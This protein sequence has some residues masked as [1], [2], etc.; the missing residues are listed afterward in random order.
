MMP[1]EEL[2]PLKGMVRSAKYVGI[3]E[4]IHTAG[5]YSDGRFR[6]T[7]FLIEEMGFRSVGIEAPY[8]AV[9]PINDYVSTC[10]GS[11]TEAGKSIYRPWKDQGFIDFIKWA[12]QYNKGH[13]KDPIYFYGFDAQYQTGYALDALKRYFIKANFPLSEKV[14]SK[15]EKCFGAESK[16]VDEFKKSESFKKYLAG[17]AIPESSHN[18]CL[19]GLEKTSVILQRHQKELI[20]K[21]SK[22]K[23]MWANIHAKTIWSDE[24]HFYFRGKD[25]GEAYFS[26]DKGMA[27][28]VSEIQNTER[29]KT[30]VVLWAHNAHLAM[31]WAN[32]KPQTY[33]NKMMGMILSEKWKENYFPIAQIGYH[34]TVNEIDFGGEDI[35][36]E[37]PKSTAENSLEYFFHRMNKVGILADARMPIFSKPHA[38]QWMDQALE[39]VP[40]EQFRAYIFHEYSRPF[41]L[42]KD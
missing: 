6:I 23:W 29:P 33:G 16:T 24:G 40:S 18:E 36:W 4:A 11:P 10:L 34:V 20:R 30:K 28:F 1:F 27:D 25:E 39:F 21:S 2:Q 38:S 5:G 17:E 12:C 26:R 7:R 19:A 31:D 3:G 22:K 41:I 32:V 9:F 15:L 14:T 42:W 35:G 37:Q 8:S 13:T